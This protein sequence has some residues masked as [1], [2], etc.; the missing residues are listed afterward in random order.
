M[1]VRFANNTTVFI[2]R[3][4]KFS[5]STIGI[6]TIWGIKKRSKMP[7]SVFFIDKR[8]AKSVYQLADERLNARPPKPPR[9]MVDF[10][11]FDPTFDDWLKPRE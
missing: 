4:G 2:R 9:E 6:S 11:P 10:M 5:V 3:D 7:P 8:I 1:V